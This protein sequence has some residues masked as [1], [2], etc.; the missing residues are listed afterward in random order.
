MKRIDANDPNSVRYRMRRKRF[1]HLEQL[2]RSVL[3]EQN[4][5]SILDIGGTRAYWDL[6]SPELRSGV[7]VTV[8]NTAQELKLHGSSGDDIE[9]EDVTGNGCHMPEFADKAF[10][11]AHSNSV[12]EHV[13][14]YRN[15]IRMAGETRRVGRGYFVQVPYWWFPLE[16][17]YGLPFIHWLP[18]LLRIKL[19][20]TFNVGYASKCTY[21]E[22][23]DRVDY[24][25]LVDKTLMRNLFPDGKLLREPYLFMT[26]SLIMIRS[27]QDAAVRT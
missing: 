4:R 11:I 8:L 25:H 13:G 12:I 21:R 10:D 20:S 19:H 23:M 14:S 22:A 15:M 18:D 27:P 24:V 26:K 6:L 3:R 7:H 1:A 2:I 9:F 16:P 5:V 17:H